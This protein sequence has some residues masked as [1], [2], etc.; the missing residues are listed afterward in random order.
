MLM[1]WIIQTVLWLGVIAALLFIPAGTVNWT[2]AWIFLT[3][4]FVASIVLGLGLARHDPE[5]LKERLRLP[6][7]KGQSNKD[8]VVTGLIVLL[9]L[10]WFAFMAFDLNG[11]RSR[12]GCKVQ[13][14]SVSC[15]GATSA[16]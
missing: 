16:I 13:A 5:L 7:Q 11:L 15:L 8:K 1:K 9:Y 14:R 2:G 10:G 4:T 3:E 12:P 6:I